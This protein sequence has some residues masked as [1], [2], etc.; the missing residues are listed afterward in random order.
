MYRLRF[1]TIKQ[2]FEIP[3]DVSVMGFDDNIFDAAWIPS[4]TTMGF[5]KAAFGRKAFELLYK[6]IA[7]GTTGSYVQKLSL[8][9]RDSTG[10]AKK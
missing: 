6:N 7:E 2:L 1:Q 9:P 8:I 3:E 5:S 10:S 4:I